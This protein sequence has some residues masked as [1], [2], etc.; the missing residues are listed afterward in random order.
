MVECFVREHRLLIKSAFWRGETQDTVLCQ[1]ADL[2]LGGAG[3]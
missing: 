1:L 3:E 2:F